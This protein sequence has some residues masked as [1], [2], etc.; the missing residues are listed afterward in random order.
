[1]YPLKHGFRILII[2]LI[3]SGIVAGQS[4]DSTSYDSVT[5]KQLRARFD[6]STLWDQIFAVP[7]EVLFFP[8]DLFLMGT[9]QGIVF[10]DNSK[11]IPR[12]IDFLTSDDGK[13]G[14]FPTYSSR[15]GGGI[16]FYQ[17]SL[18]NSQSELSLKL[19]AGLHFRQNYEI[20]LKGISLFQNA[21]FMNLRTEY[22]LLTTESFFGIGPDSKE[23]AKTTYSHEMMLAE[24]IG[25][26]QIKDDLYW[27]TTLGYEINNILDGR[28]SSHPKIG[29]LYSLKVLPGLEAQINM[30]RFETS[31]KM[32]TKNR[33]GN[34][35]SGMEINLNGGM[36]NQVNE[37][38]YG[39]WKW[40]V[41][42]SKYFHLFYD[43]VLV[44]RAAGEFT[45]PF[46][47]SQVPFFYLSELGRQETIRGFSRGRFR[48][49]DYVLGSLEYRFPVSRGLD[50]LLFVD[51]GQV[52]SD[53]YNK[54][55]NENL[56][57]TYGGGLRFWSKNG[58]IT[59]LLIGRSKD[60]I[61][62]IFNLN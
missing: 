30:I 4:T 6:N 57:T 62:V 10:V 28:E 3:Y 37:D 8:L 39:F 22:Q 60:G 5:V 18:F 12:T 48:D 13:R 50:A 2:I 9:K 53:I 45:E 52:S 41:D 1:M 43:R 26:Y 58:L 46:Q 25:I 23:D 32:D 17:K 31:F 49:R 55:S 19:T 16:K 56:E 15:T 47:D 34:P 44:V 11:I 38:R 54:Y 21:F 7:G 20:K 14:V 51:G 59:Q 35:T 42:I 36:Y 61:R 40:S 33:P 27:E 24:A 29:E